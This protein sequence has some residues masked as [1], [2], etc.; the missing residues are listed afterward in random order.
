MAPEPL[1]GLP[2]NFWLTA[3]PDTPHRKIMNGQLARQI[4]ATVGGIVIAA[5][6]VSAFGTYTKVGRME[7][8]IN[9]FVSRVDK[10]HEDYNAR[11]RWLERGRGPP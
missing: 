2:S 5:A 9:D 8:Q 4:F 7:Q 11:I 10:A 6:V 3:M 1:A